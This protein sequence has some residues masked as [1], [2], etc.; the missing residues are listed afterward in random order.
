MYE[1]IVQAEP[2]NHFAR[3]RSV[4]L[5]VRVKRRPGIHPH[6]EQAR[7]DWLQRRR[8]VTLHPERQRQIA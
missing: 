6:V 4:T 8:V 2:G 5:F 3:L 7:Q 1:R